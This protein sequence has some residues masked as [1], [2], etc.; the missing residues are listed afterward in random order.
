MPEVPWRRVIGLRNV[1]IHR[2]RDV[3]IETVWRVVEDEIPSLLKALQRHAD[4]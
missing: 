4:E 1:L 3:D 2:Y